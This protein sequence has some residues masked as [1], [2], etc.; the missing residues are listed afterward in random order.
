MK[1]CL[2]KIYMV[3]KVHYR[4][5]HRLNSLILDLG[6]FV[7]D[8][9]LPRLSRER[10][11]LKLIRPTV[12]QSVRP[13]VCHK[14]FNLAHIFWSINDRAL[15]FGMY[16]PCDKP[17]LLIPCSD[18]DLWPT[19]RSNL[20]PGGGQQFFEFACKYSTY[21]ICTNF[22]LSAMWYYWSNELCEFN[23]LNEEVD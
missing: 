20:L 2:I 11:T 8:F 4:Y 22:D 14:N 23:K 6:T 21:V 16:D 17:F 9:Y 13:S 1:L 10:V 12:C 5:L 18:L 7:N 3:V 19:L 15:I